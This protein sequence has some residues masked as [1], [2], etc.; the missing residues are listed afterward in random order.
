L[1]GYVIVF[2]TGVSGWSIV[3]PRI[4]EQRALRVALL[5]MLI[6]CLCLL[7]LNHSGEETRLVRWILVGFSV[8]CIMVESGFTPAAL[9]LLAG[10]IGAQTGRGA[11]MGIYSV[12]LSIGAIAG[13]FLAAVSGQVF[14]VDGLIYST[15]A[16]AVIA[17]FFVRWIE[18]GLFEER[19]NVIG[20][21]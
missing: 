13:S 19:T 2:G 5:A 17:L 9:S 7:V 4:G 3:L 18:V 6:V 8:L 15:L 21:V 12:L 11:A 14:A 20:T 10:A 1:L 16:M